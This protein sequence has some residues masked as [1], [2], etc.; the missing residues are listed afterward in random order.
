MTILLVA[1]FMILY[2]LS[3]AEAYRRGFRNGADWMK[4]LHK[5]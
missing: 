3:V 4:R 2:A 5:K 1:V